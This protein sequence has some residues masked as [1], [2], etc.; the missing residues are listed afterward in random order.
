MWTLIACGIALLA[1]GNSIKARSETLVALR[2][3]DLAI[4][5]GQATAAKVDEATQKFDDS[6]A[7][8]SA[9][10]VLDLGAIVSATAAEAASGLEKLQN[11]INFIWSGVQSHI[12]ADNEPEV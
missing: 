3:L 5:A 11:Q 9:E 7:A 1:L 2:L 8:A 10:M 12:E 6:T 4:D